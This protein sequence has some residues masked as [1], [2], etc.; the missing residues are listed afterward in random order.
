MALGAAIVGDSG[1]LPP[2]RW[3]PA[4]ASSTAARRC[5]PA[6]AMMP[7]VSF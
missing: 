1:G 3:F 4:P 5:Q 6:Y 2:M 7:P